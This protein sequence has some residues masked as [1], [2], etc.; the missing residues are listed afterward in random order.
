MIKSC[1]NNDALPQYL[2]FMPENA[3]LI[4]AEVCWNRPAFFL[5]KYLNENQFIKP[6]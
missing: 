1:A 2:N 5:K 4:I 3:M 6:A